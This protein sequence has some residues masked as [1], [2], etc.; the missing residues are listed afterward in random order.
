MYEWTF[1]PTSSP[2]PIVAYVLDNRHSNWGEIES[3]WDLKLQS[4]VGLWWEN[5]I[6]FEWVW[7][8]VYSA[9]NLGLVGV[10]G[11][12]LRGKSQR[13]LAYK[14]LILS[15]EEAQMDHSGIFCKLQWN[16][17]IFS[18]EREMRKNK[19]IL[20]KTREEQNHANAG[21]ETWFM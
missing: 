4:K 20:R 14:L 8:E 7:V 9:S 17:T 21:S 11:Q 15:I 19:I 18:W 13:I 5:L 1:F 6:G 3:Y 10:Q 12:V 16:Q 2:T